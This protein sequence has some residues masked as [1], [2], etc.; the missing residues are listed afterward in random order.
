[1]KIGYTITFHHSDNI[2]PNGKKVLQRNIESLYSSC[3]K[4][5]S[6]YIIDNQSVPRASFSEVIDINKYNNMKYTYIENQFERGITGAWSDGVKQAI[7]DECDI[8]ILT[9]DDTIINKSINNLIDYIHND[10]KSDNSIYGPMANG[11]TI[12]L[13]LSN[14]PI[15]EIKEIAGYPVPYHLGGHMYAF[16]KEFYHKWKSPNGDL[17]VIDNPHNGGDGKWGGN[18]GNVIHWAEQGAR[19]VI[20]GTCWIEHSLDTRFSY[21][22]AKSLD[23]NK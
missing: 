10:P 16:T 13:Q 2:R 9:T 18:E 15:D 4:N 7:E 5:F 8:I 21:R 12:P 20:V 6:S 11:I 22:I 3:N 1:M 17:F 14:E 19:C 23:K